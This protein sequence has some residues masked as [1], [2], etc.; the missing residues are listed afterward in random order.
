MKVLVCTFVALLSLRVASV[1]ENPPPSQ[2]TPQLF[3]GA[4]FV[5]RDKDLK[6]QKGGL[7]LGPPVSDGKGGTKG[8]FAVY[9]GASLISDSG[10]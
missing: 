7:V 4:D 6:P 5:L 2:G 9:G 8:S 3:P 1:Q 10:K